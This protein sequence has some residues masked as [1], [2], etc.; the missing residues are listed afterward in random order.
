M[1][2]RASATRARVPDDR[3]SPC[4]S[5]AA[6][7]PSGRGCD[8]RHALAA[9]RAP[10]TRPVGLVSVVFVTRVEREARRSPDSRTRDRRSALLRHSARARSEAA[11]HRFRCPG[12]PHRRRRSPGTNG[13]PRDDESPFPRRPD[14]APHACLRRQARRDTPRSP[15]R[16]A[17]GQHAA[18]QPERRPALVV[19]RPDSEKKPKLAQIPRQALSPRPNTLRAVPKR[20]ASRASSSSSR[21]VRPSR[22]REG[23]SIGQLVPKRTRPRPTPRR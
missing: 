18:R 16:R 4:S 8:P 22:Q 7:R 12:G 19:A 11:S 5:T 23:E 2:A 17:V 10:A 13:A 3:F 21:P 9:G 6:P 20:N 1:Q 14:R 15:L